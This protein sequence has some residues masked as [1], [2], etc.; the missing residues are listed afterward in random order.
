MLREFY[1]QNN[2]FLNT[3]LKFVTRTQSII[4]NE[5]IIVRKTKSSQKFRRI[6]PADKSSPTKKSRGGKKRKSKSNINNG[7]IPN[8]NDISGC[9][10]SNISNEISQ[11][12]KSFVSDNEI[13]SQSKINFLKA[14]KGVTKN[15]LKEIKQKGEEIP[16]KLDDAVQQDLLVESKMNGP[17]ENNIPRSPLSLGLNRDEEINNFSRDMQLLDESNIPN[18]MSQQNL[19]FNSNI[20]DDMNNNTHK[21]NDKSNTNKAE[22]NNNGKNIIT[23]KTNKSNHKTNN[24]NNDNNFKTNKSNKNNTN[25]NNKIKNFNTVEKENLAQETSRP[26]ELSIQNKVNDTKNNSIK[27]QSSKKDTTN[28][29][30]NN[31]LSNTLQVDQT[32]RNHKKK[33]TAC[34]CQI[35]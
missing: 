28:F 19:S 26:V 32:P 5:R 30:A 6:I 25:N 7:D 33:S 15:V 23:Y 35:F 14:M 11:N 31:G 8:P 22:N 2:H 27:P 12:Q 3:I 21:S 16:I 17:G 20:M 34:R 18:D 24:N 13:V 9:N 10:I 1:D 4:I 29:S